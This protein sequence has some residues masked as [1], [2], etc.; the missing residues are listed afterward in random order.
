MKITRSEEFK[1]LLTVQS[2]RKKILHSEKQKI[3]EI[4][5]LIAEALRQI[6][7]INIIHKDINP[8]NIVFNAAKQQKKA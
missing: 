2:S 4:F 8:S 7:S 5:I 1:W 3:L 6:H